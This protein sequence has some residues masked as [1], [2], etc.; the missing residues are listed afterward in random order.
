MD[1][2]RISY[3][4]IIRILACI[5]ILL[6]HSP[7][8]NIGI[9]SYLLSSISFLAAPGIG[10]FFMVSGTLILPVTMPYK[11]FLKRRISK[12]VWPTIIWTLFYIGIN[13]YYK[14]LPVIDIPRTILSIPF[15]PQGNSVL[16]FVYSLIGL[17][18]ISP[19]I[20]PWLI[21]ASKKE[22]EFLLLIWGIYLCY[23]ILKLFISTYEGPNSILYY[24]GGNIGYFI[25]GY[26]LK[27]FKICPYYWKILLLFII[28]ITI[29]TICK[30]SHL[31]I[32]FYDLFWFKSIFFVS[33][34][35]G[36]FLLTKRLSLNLQSNNLITT[37]SNC[38]FGV[39][40]IHIF[41]M[42]NFLWNLDFISA[43][44]GLVQIISTTILTLVISYLLVFMISKLPYSKYII[45]Y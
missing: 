1:K 17:Y 35:L 36:W 44:G 24:F 10:L 4:D 20:S 18:L 29:A 21:K 43:Y 22:I 9:N 23:P 41:I 28:P 40:L 38:S 45:G 11:E 34:V 7:M 13:I 27:R 32:D 2:D 8:P 15:S 6:V 12:V 31:K 14:N 37:L 25:L 19:I 16:W 26:Y 5:L 30:L 42:R 33:I 39:Y 3:L